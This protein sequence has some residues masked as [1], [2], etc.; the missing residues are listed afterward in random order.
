MISGTHG[1]SC[2]RALHE[3]EGR[4]SVSVGVERERGPLSAHTPSLFLFSRSSSLAVSRSAAEHSSP[5]KAA[6]KATRPTGAC[7]PR[8]LC[9][10]LLLPPPFLC[11]CCRAVFDTKALKANA[12]GNNGK[13]GSHTHTRTRRP[14]AGGA[15]TAPHGHVWPLH[16]FPLLSTPPPTPGR[17]P[18][19]RSSLS[20]SPSAMGSMDWLQD[21]LVVYGLGVLSIAFLLVLALFVC[22]AGAEAESEPA[23][24]FF[25]A[26]GADSDDE[27]DD[28]DEEKRRRLGQVR[29]SH[30]RRVVS[31]LCLHSVFLSPLRCSCLAQARARARAGL[32]PRIIS[33]GSPFCGG[34]RCA[35]PA[36][37]CCVP[38]TA[39]TACC[40][41]RRCW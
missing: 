33:V 26:K 22:E 35:W 16:L 40:L 8:P 4:R 3:L 27:E 20:F 18:L 17:L 19:S 2:H 13:R 29:Q 28:A 12:Q 11:N 7:F 10:L 6:D 1:Q 24:A 41:H 34:A 25:D 31:F 14:E 32:Q 30:A 23:D 5:K 21:F 9:R 39:C 36:E 37:G 15:R 38:A